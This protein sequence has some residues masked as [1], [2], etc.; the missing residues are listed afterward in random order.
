M[1]G[2]EDGA[3]VGHEGAQELAQPADP[4]WV[5]AVGGLV[6]DEQLRLGEQRCRQAQSLAQPRENSPTLRSPAWPRP[7]VSRTWSTR[8]VPM[9]A[10]VAIHWRWLRAVRRGW[11]DAGSS[12]TPTLRQGWSS[13]AYG[14]PHTVATPEVALASPRTIRIVVVFPAPLGP[15]N[16]VTRPAGTSKLR[17]STARRDPNALVRPRVLITAVS[18]VAHLPFVDLLRT[19]RAGLAVVIVAEDDPVSSLRRSGA[20][21]A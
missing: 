7:T 16:P 15:R 9:P 13:S 10:G 4:R 17:S 12:I 20:G 5:Q 19:V 3:A 18:I 14:R 8:F 1:A 11:T 2:Q 6:E 21:A